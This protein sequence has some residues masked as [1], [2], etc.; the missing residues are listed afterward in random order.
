MARPKCRN[1]QWLKNRAHSPAPFD[2]A[3]PPVAFGVEYLLPGTWWAVAVAVGLSIGA[4]VALRVT[5]PPAGGD[6]ILV[7][8]VGPQLGFL[9]N[10]VLLAGLI[11]VATATI[12]DHLSG[13]EY[14]LRNG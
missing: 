1:P 7:F 6:P 10:P 9:I 4:M 13:T 5:H 11:L 2:T 8:A 14:P 3:A 12:Y